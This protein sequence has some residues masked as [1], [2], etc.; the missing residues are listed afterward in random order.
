MTLIGVLVLGAALGAC[1]GSSG[2][3]AKSTTSAPA[4]NATTTVPT[5]GSV[6]TTTPATN[7]P[8]AATDL[9]RYFA[10]ASDA[11]QRLRSTA[12]KVN[13]AIGTT[14]VTVDQSTLDA[15]DA[16][17]PSRAA[18]EI[19]AG[20][21][22]SVLLPV[23]TVQSDLVSRYSSLRGFRL[24]LANPGQP[25]TFPISDPAV[26]AALVCLDEGAA[27]A[28]SFSGDL[29][30][31]RTAAAKAPPAPAV[32][33]ASRTAADLAI[34]LENDKFSNQAGAGCG[35]SRVTSLAPITWHHVDPAQGDGRPW[36]GD[37][38]GL[39]FA[40]TYQAGHGW[41]VLFHGN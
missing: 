19:P 37:M 35:G 41:S 6:A 22:P 23:L 3:S 17:D 40:A 4:S 1:S 31:A 32:E 39:L 36:D 11:D 2:S 38:A 20:L 33:A 18:L 15:I 10:A 28:A 30:S 8:S 34:R 12:D 29:A 9:G 5:A 13:G 26:H 25:H 7:A 27:A 24:N 16:S 14:Q 21:T